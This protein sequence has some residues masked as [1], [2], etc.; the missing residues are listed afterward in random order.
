MMSVETVNQTFAAIV[1]KNHPAG[2]SIR[3][4]IWPTVVF[5]NHDQPR[6]ASRFAGR[7]AERDPDLLDAYARAAAVLE[8]TLRGTPFLYYGE[9]IG[10]PSVAIPRAEIVDPPARRATWWSPWWNRDQARTPMQWSSGQNAGFTSGRPWL[11]AG[12]DPTGRRNVAAQAADPTSVLAVYRRLI[13]L[14]RQ[15]PVLRVGSIRRLP[16]SDRDVLVYER[17]ADADRVLVAINFARRPARVS[18][19]G[20]W[21]VRLSSHDSALE[22]L[23]LRGELALRSLEAV[24]LEAG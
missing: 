2:S 8:L 15:L 13:W 16:V 18:L 11:R 14:R 19:D 20:G 23:D 1:T 21:R 5:S 9:E 4:L 7:A 12:P 3:P 17:R 24:I 22:S 6:H 10:M